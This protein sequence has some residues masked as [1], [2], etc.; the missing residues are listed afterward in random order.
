MAHIAVIRMFKVKSLGSNKYMTIVIEASSNA[1][2][3]VRL[4]SIEGGSLLQ[5]RAIAAGMYMHVQ[6]ECGIY[7][8]GWRLVRRHT[9]YPPAKHSASPTS[10][11]KRKDPK[12]PNDLTY[13]H[14][15]T[16][17]MYSTLTTGV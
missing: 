16:A 2:K 14:M 7:W 15:K 11:E 3:L 12:C 9:R 8:S 1:N 4:L 10:L 17:C 13:T 5:A 6:S